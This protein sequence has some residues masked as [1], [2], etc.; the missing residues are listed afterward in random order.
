MLNKVLNTFENEILIFWI[1]AEINPEK[2]VLLGFNKDTQ[3][4]MF[5]KLILA[6]NQ[7]KHPLKSIMNN[8]PIF[9]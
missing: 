2:K 7:P 3:P 4:P 1:E 8:K 5:G 9:A 6:K